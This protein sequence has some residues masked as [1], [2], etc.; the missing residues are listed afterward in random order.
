MDSEFREIPRP[1]RAGAVEVPAPLI[2]PPLR[3][4]PEWP[5][6]QLERDPEPF[7]VEPG[8]DIEGL[9]ARAQEVAQADPRVREHL[10]GGRVAWIGAGVLDAKDD[11][12]PSAVAVAFDYDRSL[13]VEVRL[14]GKDGNF[15]VIDVADVAYH[16]APS[17]EEIARATELARSDRRVAEQLSEEL[18]STAILVSDVEQGDRHYGSRRIEIGFGRADER[19]PL[20]RALVDLGEERV[21]GVHAEN[22]YRYESGGE[23]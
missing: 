6:A 23:R 14:A 22:G 15:E 10:G 8:D 19:L 20:I 2:E 12:G 5:G 11:E 17:D 7:E 21:L 18:E 16:P 13:A 3:E 9:V 1:T 4:M